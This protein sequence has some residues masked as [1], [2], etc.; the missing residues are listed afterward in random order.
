M[1]LT[2][3]ASNV[4][5][6]LPRAL[7]SLKTGG[8][9]QL[10]R[11]HPS[12]KPFFE[13]EIL[14]EARG[15]KIELSPAELGR[16]WGVAPSTVGRWLSF[17][18]SRGWI[19]LLDGRGGRGRPSTYRVIWLERAEEFRRARKSR[20]QER[21]EWREKFAEDPH[22]RGLEIV[23]LKQATDR[24]AKKPL[25]KQNKTA[26]SPDLKRD[27]GESNPQ[28]LVTQTLDTNLLDTAAGSRRER[29]GGFGKIPRPTAPGERAE[30][31]RAVEGGVL[32]VKHGRY[33]RWVMEQFRLIAWR[34]GAARRE[35]DIVANAVGRLIDGQPISFARRLAMWLQNHI[36]EL[37]RRLRGALKDGL[38]AAYASVSFAIRVGLKLL[39]PKSKPES[40]QR[41]RAS[42]VKLDPRRRWD[43]NSAKGRGEFLKLAR[44]IADRGGGR[45]P[46]C[47]RRITPALF[48]I[49][50]GLAFEREGLCSCI[51]IAL[52]R[53]ARAAEIREGGIS[54]RKRQGEDEREA[55]FAR[56]MAERGS[57]PT[58][59]D[60]RGTLA[61]IAEGMVSKKRRDAEPDWGWLNAGREE[62][63][64]RKRARLEAARRWA[65]ERGG[66]HG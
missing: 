22:L 8:P 37:L 15:F 31:L 60:W 13:E 5:H 23:D 56:R 10:H 62:L 16:R 51:Y 4:K 25:K 34:G 35:S 7:R 29:Q 1:I 64:R 55:I 12:I 65:L 41:S 2:Q 30:A 39:Q 11:F 19:E 36:A 20:A 24:W 9:R 63:E 61:S 66:G 43:L 49:D 28:G 32:L 6:P 48:K 21:A 33:Y 17:Y 58:P 40:K 27:I 44:E 3:Q 47:G 54:K 14:A 59:A 50:A 46:R 52:D 57:A 42:R 38:R 53:Q 18:R 26:F 45:C